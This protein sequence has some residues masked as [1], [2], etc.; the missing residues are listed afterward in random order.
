[1]DRRIEGA[2]LFSAIFVIA[3]KTDDALDPVQGHLEFE[4]QSREAIVA[5][6]TATV[7]ASNTV[8]AEHLASASSGAR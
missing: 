1:M 8:A 3:C 4:A 6:A 5:Y 2:I 7:T